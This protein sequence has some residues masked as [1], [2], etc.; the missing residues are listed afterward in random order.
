MKL[1]HL[2]LGLAAMAVATFGMATMT[3]ANDATATY[4]PIGVNTLTD[5][6]D[7]SEISN[8]IGIS[9]TCDNMVEKGAY[10]Y[11]YTFTLKSPAYVNINASAN[12]VRYNFEGDFNLY[13]SNSK[14]FT[15][16]AICS[17]WANGDSDSYTTALDA[18]TYYLKAE[19]LADSTP[20]AAKIFSLS[21]YTQPVVRTGNVRG[22]NMKIAIPTSNKG[23]ASYGFVSDT[24]KKQWFKFNVSSQSDVSFLTVLTSN[25]SKVS[26]NV[27]V[28]DANGSS[29]T[30]N[31]DIW[32]DDKGNT[33]AF[34][35]KGMKK[36][37][38][39]VCVWTTSDKCYSIKQTV[40]AKDIYAPNAPSI[41]NFKSG[42]KTI[43]GKA[44]V[45]ST[46]YVKYN[47]KTYKTA[48]SNLGTYKVT[49]PAL[50]VGKSISVY[51]IDSSKNKSKITTKKV[52][53]RRLS[54]PSVKK[55]KK[56]TKVVSG[57]A[58]K[59]T[60][61]YVSYNGKTYKS[62]VKS[63]GTYSVKTKTLKKGKKVTVKIVD[64]YGNY[65]N[66]KKITIK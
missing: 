17:F 47:G 4:G 66:T 62:K 23:T 34:T 37:T 65:S 45:G 64:A 60:T 41:V 7:K 21:V 32:G 44:E 13:L 59:G 11:Y 16:N 3:Y 30:E 15:N 31:Y 53:N 9:N 14:T 5:I 43:S 48:A 49:V 29:I 39:Y 61:V 57:K 25:I 33:A 19:A 2:V 18:G 55:Y 38:Y 51:A 54:T 22:S 46:V 42:T 50:K 10:Y 1:K 56:N 24:I 12:F 58:K 28:Y 40:K 36:G 63:N 27:M 20:I 8:A 6:N 35:L 52:A 26:G